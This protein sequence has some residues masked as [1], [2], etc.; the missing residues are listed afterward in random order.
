MSGG[1][2]PG[3]RDWV[4]AY[5]LEGP[6]AHFYR[7]PHLHGLAP[8]QICGNL[9]YVGDDNVGIHLI[10]T[11]QGLVLVDSGY[12]EMQAWLIQNLWTLGFSPAQVR[13]V[14]HTHAHF[15]HMGASNLIRALSGARLLL[16]AADGRMMEEDPGLVFADCHPWCEGCLFRPDGA[17]QDGD[18]LTLGR[19][20]I[21]V[22]AA[23]GHTP[24]T[25]AV[26]FT[27]Q[28][29]S[30]TY[31]AGL[32]GGVGFNTMTAEFLRRHGLHG[33]RQAFAEGLK[34]LAEEPV[35]ILLGNHTRQNNLLEK[36]RQLLACPQGENPFVDRRQWPLFLRETAAQ[37]AAFTAADPE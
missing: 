10:D 18:Q 5:G 1:P 31:V 4:D 20:R 27:V 13:Y 16:S 28:D 2:G 7:Y 37:F 14:L 9:Y 34:R 17:L 29:G 35:D 32:H 25:L 36:R 24:G 23:P 3:G 26:F 30:A 22:R 6:A 15:D 19:T 11:G 12:P 21:W 8:F 33:M